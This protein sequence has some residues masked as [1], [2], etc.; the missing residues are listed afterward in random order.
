MFG[1]ASHVVLT[2]IFTLP[3]LAILW[4]SYFRV[5]H[6]DWKVIAKVLLAYFPLLFVGDIWAISNQVWSFSPGLVTGF[7]VW[8][9]SF[10]D[11][12]FGLMVTLVVSSATLVGI[13]FRR[14]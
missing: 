14:F 6:A 3:P 2:L 9:A 7:S 1:H 10:D 13:S 11:L 8:G 4:A 12:F 5:L